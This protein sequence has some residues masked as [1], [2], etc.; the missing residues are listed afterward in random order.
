M[1]PAMLASPHTAT[2]SGCGPITSRTA[3][4]STTSPSTDTSRTIGPPGCATSMLAGTS[5]S[6]SGVATR[7]V[8]VSR[9]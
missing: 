9:V 2:T 1:A 7:P 3:S 5:G 6:P 4:S 8:S